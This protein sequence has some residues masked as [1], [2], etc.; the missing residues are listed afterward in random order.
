VQ[1]LDWLILSETHTLS[2]RACCLLSSI[3]DNKGQGSGA[4][5]SGMSF[6][7]DESGLP[8]A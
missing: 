5:D 2:R 6:G 3:G 4:S 7:P 1:I 8:Y